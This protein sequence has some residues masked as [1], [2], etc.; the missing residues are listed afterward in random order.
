V[1]PKHFVN[2]LDNKS[3]YGEN[4]LTFPYKGLGYFSPESTNKTPFI[5]SQTRTCDFGK[6]RLTEIKLKF[7]TNE[8]E[9][10]LSPNEHKLKTNNFLILKN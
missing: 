2:F 3:N 1:Q 8:V 7:A 6:V 5:K 4:A 10:K 9:V